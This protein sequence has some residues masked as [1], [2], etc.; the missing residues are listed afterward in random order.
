MTGHRPLSELTQKMLPA[1][2]ERIA[3]ATFELRDAMALAELRQ[4]LNRTQADLSGHMRVRQPAVARLETRSDMHVSN[5]RRYV[6]ALGGTLQIVATINGTKVE[7]TNFIPADPLPKAIPKR[8]P[9][10][11]SA[12]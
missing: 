12:A 3:A 1:R 5:L 7:I 11:R 6:E 10:R 9:R 2:K 4:A 8:K